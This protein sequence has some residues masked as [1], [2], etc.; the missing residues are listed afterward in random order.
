VPAGVVCWTNGCVGLAHWLRDRPRYRLLRGA[1]ARADHVLA[2]S[3]WLRRALEQE[4]IEAEALALPA[5]PP[6]SGYV[7]TRS[8]R[9]VF[10]FVGRLSR[11]KGVASLIRA[12]A[13]ARN[14]VP[15]AQLRIVGEGDERPALER[16]ASSLGL[17]GSV[18]F[19]G[20]LSLG[21]VEQELAPAWASVAPSIWAEPFGLVAIEAIVRGV[22]VVAS[23]HGGMA[24][25]VEPDRTGL[26]FPNGDENEL[27]RCL[28]AVGAGRAFGEGSLP[29][30]V[31]REAANRHSV[32][33]YV[34][35]IERIASELRQR[36][37]RGS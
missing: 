5:A 15:D 6:L 24:E 22:P 35:R 25:V 33:R 12:F 4:G 10:V 21:G 8:E 13:Q 23:L 19:R 14:A 30:H 16:L 31:V 2:C 26:L 34:A 9:P 18:V 11:E 1:I 7:R 3:A 32:E 29:T 27:A 20:Q 36:R 28:E 37:S 17:E